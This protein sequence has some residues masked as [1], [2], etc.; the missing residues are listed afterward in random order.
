MEVGVLWRPPT[1]N[2]LLQTTLM[3]KTKNEIIAVW[4]IPAA[5]SSAL[6]KAIFKP[7][8]IVHT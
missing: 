4:N 6:L 2:F 5:F 3:L 8:F 7:S 1:S